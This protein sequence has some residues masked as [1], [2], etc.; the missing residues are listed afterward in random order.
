MLSILGHPMFISTIFGVTG[1]LSLTMAYIF[2]TLVH[3][4][5]KSLTK[6]LIVTGAWSFT[7]AVKYNLY[8]NA[9]VGIGFTYISLVL[10]LFSVLLWVQFIYSYLGKEIPLSFK[11]RQLAIGLFLLLLV[12]KV[13]NPLHELYFTID[14]SQE[15]SHYT[16][17]FGY[18]YIAIL[19][20]SYLIVFF[21]TYQ[22]WS[23]RDKLSSVQ[24]KS[25]TLGLIVLIIPSFFTIYSHISTDFPVLFFDGMGLALFT[26]I[27]SLTEYR[28]QR[29]LET[30]VESKLDLHTETS[31]IVIDSDKRV[32]R[33][34]E[35]AKEVFP[36]L[37][38]GSTF[39]SSEELSLT[40][41]TQ[42]ILN[43][44]YYNITV[45]S[46]SGSSLYAAICEDV[47]EKVKSK[48]QVEQRNA[49]LNE[50]SEALTHE[51]RNAVNII[52][53]NLEEELKENPE[54]MYTPKAL[55]ASKRLQ[56]VT[57]DL[58]E[59]T[60]IPTVSHST[61]EIKLVDILP[62]TNLQITIQQEHLFYSDRDIV[63]QI[64][65]KAITFAELNNATELLISETDDGF[66]IQDNG[67]TLTE[68]GQPN[69]FKFGHAVPNAEIGSHPPVIR[70]LANSIGWSTDTNKDTLETIGITYELN[71]V[72]FTEETLD[73]QSKNSRTSEETDDSSN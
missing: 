53:G 69:L 37:E 13:T 11:Q 39:L 9:I 8:E 27:I 61:T 48:K 54:L 58:Q 52:S 63:S 41:L 45:V 21:G 50:F 33:T 68:E 35:V 36:E 22:L 47:T 12:F 3:R 10:G 16:Y 7:E 66:C 73:S 2:S 20:I 60:K 72:K 26:S 64:F 30:T 56:R 42:I 25:I 24:T 40:K 38:I 31:V 67:D 51:I 14:F 43:D 70:I 5:Y 62:K 29:N 65:D 6:L 28:T 19:L 17:N 15:L 49:Q 59:L 23:Y 4:E 44:R 18:V 55:D 71:G 1:V 32:L 34:N 57:E 46:L